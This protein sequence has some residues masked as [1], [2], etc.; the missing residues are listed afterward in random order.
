M[1]LRRCS[2]MS[3]HRSN[4]GALESAQEIFKALLGSVV[5]RG[6]AAGVPTPVLA[7]LY[8]VLVPY[9]GGRPRD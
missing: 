7:T 6:R 3:G 5:R 4:T 2:Y 1:G 9:A 8:G